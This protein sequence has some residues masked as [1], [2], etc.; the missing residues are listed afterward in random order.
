MNELS[1]D[2]LNGRSDA[3]ARSKK[4]WLVETFL[5]SALT[6]RHASLR[7]DSLQAHAGNNQSL[8]VVPGVSSSWLVMNTFIHRAKVCK[9]APLIVHWQKCSSESTTRKALTETTD[10]GT[11][12]VAFLRC[13]C[14]KLAVLRAFPPRHMGIQMEG[15]SKAGHLSGWQ[16]EGMNK[17]T[18]VQQP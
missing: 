17:G 10:M 9:T 16:E 4:Q 11:A 14:G 8:R 12:C 13:V 2:F 3:F 7:V 5:S 18:K 1:L 6:L 15:S